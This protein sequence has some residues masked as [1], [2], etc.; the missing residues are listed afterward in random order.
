MRD[1]DCYDVDRDVANLASGYTRDEDGQW[2]TNIFMHVVRGGPAG[3]GYS[4][5]PDLLRFALALRGGKLLG[6]ATTSTFV[7]GKMDTP[8]GKYAYGFG[9]NNVRGHRIVGHSGGFPG[10]NSNLDI[11]WD[12]GYV[13]AVMSNID[14]GA[15][16][17]V[18]KARELIA[19]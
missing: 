6:P 3:G 13:V 18:D 16:P 17:V 7:T 12:D 10:M 5:A 2:R 9:D 1:T 19:R 8:R 4:T 11:Y 14:M 15:M